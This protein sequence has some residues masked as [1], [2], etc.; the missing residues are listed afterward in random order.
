MISHGRN[1]SKMLLEVLM[2][3]FILDLEQHLERDSS[4]Y[5]TRL[6]LKGYPESYYILSITFLLYI[7]IKEKKN[8]K[9][10]NSTLISL[11]K[12]RTVS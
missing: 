3:H 9:Y 5:V 6:F 4:S 11:A 8:T 7:K 2:Q 12:S 10:K 1:N